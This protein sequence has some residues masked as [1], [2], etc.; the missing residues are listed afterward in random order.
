LRSGKRQF[1]TKIAT[2]QRERPSPANN[3]SLPPLLA[4]TTLPEKLDLDF[5]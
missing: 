5:N 4:M 1:Q 3:L 2:S